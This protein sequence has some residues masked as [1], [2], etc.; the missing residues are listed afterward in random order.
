MIA[1]FSSSEKLPLLLYQ[2]HLQRLVEK[3][4]EIREKKLLPIYRKI[5]QFAPEWRESYCQ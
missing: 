1:L 4:L 3:V 5:Y 2:W